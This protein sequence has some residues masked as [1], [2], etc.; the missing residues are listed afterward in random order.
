MSQTILPAQ[1]LAGIRILDFS[2]LLPGPYCTMLLMNMGAEIVKIESPLAGD[3]LR[4]APPEFGFSAVFDLLNRGKQSVAL[5]YRNPRGREIVLRLAREADVVVESFR[6]GVMERWGLG[7]D[8]LRAVNPRLIYCALSGYGQSGPYRD[9]GGHDLNYIS[10]AGLL[11]VNAAPH[12]PPAIPGVQMAD[13]S[14]GML[15]ALEILGALV[16]RG[17]TGAG[18]YLDVSLLDGAL[19]WAAPQMAALAAPGVHL[20]LLGGDAPCYNLYTTADGQYLT[21]GALEPNFWLAFCQRVERADWIARQ[22]DPALIAEIAALFRTRPRA[23]WLEVFRDTDALEP[24]PSVA[25]AR[26]DPQVRLRWPM[27]FPGQDGERAPALGAH[28]ASVLKKLGVSAD[29]LEELKAHGVV[30]SN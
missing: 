5:N 6:P 18:R 3:H 21:L 11:A 27:L 24:V 22:F 23:E 28:T 2:R 25:E 29:E 14:G 30:K 8:A 10:I 13:L 20:R 26:H 12:Q 9:R 7:D 4:M 16:E 19:L 17:R 1:A 15:G